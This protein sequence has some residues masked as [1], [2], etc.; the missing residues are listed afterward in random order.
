MKIWTVGCLVTT[1]VLSAGQLAAA[2]GIAFSI[3][4]APEAVSPG[5]PVRITVHAKSDIP[6][7]PTP[8][9]D[10][11]RILA[12]A[13]SVSVGEALRRVESATTSKPI[14]QRRAF[15][16]ASLRRIDHDT[17][18]AR[19]RPNV[20]GR[21]TLVIPNW[22]ANGYVLPEGVLHKPLVVS[23]SVHDFPA[24]FPTPL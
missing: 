8:D 13:P 18:V 16:L 17:W 4:A 9:C 5:T 3:Q 10:R 19:L 20:L 11:M 15:R 21:W 24:G 7:E 6:G 2:K 1:I 22:C 12:V 14:D 23:R